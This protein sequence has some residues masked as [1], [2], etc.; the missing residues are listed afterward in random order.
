VKSAMPGLFAALLAAPLAGS[1]LILSGGGA[2]QAADPFFAHERP[3]YRSGAEL[4]DDCRAEDPAARGRC[5]GY[6]M[7]VADMLGGAS[8]QVDGIQACLQ[9]DETLDD[10]VLV[11]LQ[12]L[13]GDPSRANLKGDGAVAYALSIY[14]PCPE[15][16][17]T[18]E[19]R[20]LSR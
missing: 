20:L 17:A 7:A 13:E 4:L 12:H 3:R 1:L 18:F 9:G 11:V 14:R 16:D 8:A 2:A 6:V 10:L 5:A 15:G 19:E